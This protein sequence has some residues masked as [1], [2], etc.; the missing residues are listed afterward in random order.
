MSSLTILVAIAIPI[1]VSVFLF[2]ISCCF[3]RRRASKK[4]NTLPEENGEVEIPD[5]ESLQFDLDK[6]EA[7]TNK[8]SDD[9]KIGEGGFGAVYK[10]TFPNGEQ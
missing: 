8:F 5:V 9:N 7:A 4:F 1:A 3:L 6:I 2:F 10:G